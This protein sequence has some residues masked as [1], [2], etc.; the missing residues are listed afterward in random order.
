MQVT[1]IAVAPAVLILEWLMLGRTV[2]GRIMAAIAVVCAGV[3]ASTVTDPHV[4]TSV[5]GLAV[6]AAAIVA[7]ALF[8]VCYRPHVQT[9]V[10]MC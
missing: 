1:K 8:Q 5:G 6:G 3:G 10:R 9:S 4:T 7:T 2:S